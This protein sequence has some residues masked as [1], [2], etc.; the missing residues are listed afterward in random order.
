MPPT[1]STPSGAAVPYRTLHLMAG[2]NQ[3]A[4]SASPN[5]GK[6]Y[7][8][9]TSPERPSVQQTNDL[10]GNSPKY[11]ASSP[12]YGRELPQIQRKIQY[13]RTGQRYLVRHIPFTG[14]KPIPGGLRSIPRPSASGL[15]HAQFDRLRASTSPNPAIAPQSGNPV[16]GDTTMPQP[17]HHHCAGCN[18]P[19]GHRRLPPRPTEHVPICDRCLA[20]GAIVAWDGLGYSHTVTE[21]QPMPRQWRHRRL[22]QR[23]STRI[24]CCRSNRNL[25]CRRRHRRKRSQPVGSMPLPGRPP[26]RGRPPVGTPNTPRPAE[27]GK[28]TAN[29]SP[30][31]CRYPNAEPNHSHAALH[32]DRGV[33]ALPQPEPGQSRR[34]IGATGY[35][36]ASGRTHGNTDLA[37]AAYGPGVSDATRSGNCRNR[38]CR[39]DCFR[40][41]NVH[42]AHGGAPTDPASAGR[43]ASG[44]NCTPAAMLPESGG[45]RR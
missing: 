16:T 28:T 20:N 9:R 27:T 15:G 17:H 44:P 4:N 31:P 33:P 45:R 41:R 8:P 25:V 43:P 38:R 34:H 29:R 14:I 37:P 40:L 30:I 36:N 10:G 26:S 6:F 11:G 39:T 12:E 42:T 23:Y 3:T 19:V 1:G 2:A 7:R 22:G 18:T 32:H 21:I 24:P 35:A 5:Q 13:P